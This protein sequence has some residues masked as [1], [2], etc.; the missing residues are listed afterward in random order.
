[1][2]RI[3]RTRYDELEK[4]GNASAYIIFKRT[5]EQWPD[6][7]GFVFEGRSWTYAQAERQVDKL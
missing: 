2:T 7:E 5:V 4:E 3:D 1:M 6:R